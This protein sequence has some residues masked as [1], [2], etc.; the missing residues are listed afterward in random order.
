MRLSLSKYLFSLFLCLLLLPSFNAHS[1]DNTTWG[2]TKSLKKSA[3]DKASKAKHKAKDLKDHLK[4]WG[5]DSNY[6]HALLIGGKLNTD[7]WSGNIYYAKKKNYKTS[8]F[9]QLS[10]SEIKHEKQTKQQG[11]NTEYPYLGNP[12]S[13]VFGKINNLYTLQIGFGKEKLLLPAVLEGNL[14]VSFRYSGG[15]SLA[16]LKPYYLKLIYLNGNDSAQIQDEKYSTANS[17]K[18][19]NSNFILGASKWSKGLNQI[20]YMPGA[21]FESAIA[22]IPGK[23]KTFIQVITLGINAAVYA[24]S[25]PIMA[26]QNSYP[27]QVSLF[28]GIGIGKRWK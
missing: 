19:L 7:G 25:L 15:F 5:L 13:F 8:N 6:N 24:K 28:A 17:S 4:K 9:W 23:N 10:F 26:D 3:A 21:Y 2:S 1:Q 27:W 12:T 16:M 20:Y 11:S 14:S 22:I 18:F